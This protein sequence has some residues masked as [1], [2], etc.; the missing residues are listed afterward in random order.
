M[1]CIRALSFAALILTPVGVW[2]QQALLIEDAALPVVCLEGGASSW[3]ALVPLEV[4][5]LQETEMAPAVDIPGTVRTRSEHHEHRHDH[6]RHTMR[7]R[8]C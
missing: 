2:A 3:L 6:G 8:E 7:R 1:H 5:Q 4:G